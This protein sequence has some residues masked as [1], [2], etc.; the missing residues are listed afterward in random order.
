MSSSP[1]MRADPVPPGALDAVTAS[2]LP[3]FMNYG[4]GGPTS[5]KL[6]CGFLAC[7][8]QPFNPPGS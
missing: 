4:D 3:F 5:A 6:V 7:D 2:Q 8:A 1:G